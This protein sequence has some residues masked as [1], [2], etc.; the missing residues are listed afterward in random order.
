MILED[1]IINV[2]RKVGDEKENADVKPIVSF[3]P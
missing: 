2:R 3:Y 1:L